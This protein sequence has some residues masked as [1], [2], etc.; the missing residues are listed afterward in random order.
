VNNEPYFTKVEMKNPV[1][2][3]RV[4]ETTGV[5]IKTLRKLN[6]DVKPGATIAVKKDVTHHV[7]VAVD[8]ADVAV[9]V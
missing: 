4:A 5:N 1:T 6:P 7:L 2:L 9:N 3:D 8:K